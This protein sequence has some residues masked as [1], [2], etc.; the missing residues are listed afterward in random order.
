MNG[1]GGNPVLH[2]KQNINPLNLI[3]NFM[4]RLHKHTVTLYFVRRMY[5]LVSYDP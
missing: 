1:Y 2:D 5:L 3:G 4:Y